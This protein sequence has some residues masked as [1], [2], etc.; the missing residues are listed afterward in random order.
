MSFSRI[1]CI[2]RD[3]QRDGGLGINPLDVKQS[4][5]WLLRNYSVKYSIT[6][7]KYSLLSIFIM[8]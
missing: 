6:F 4:P 8:F 7:S 2:F 1:S 5:R 3:L